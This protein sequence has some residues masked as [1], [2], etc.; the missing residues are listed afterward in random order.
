MRREAR[1][2]R[3]AVAILAC[4]FVSREAISPRDEELFA[5]G[6]ASSRLIIRLQQDFFLR[7]AQ[8]ADILILAGVALSCA[9]F[10]RAVA[11]PVDGPYRVADRKKCVYRALAKKKTMPLEEG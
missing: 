9:P 6:L 5:T 3:G 8:V 11:L 7:R 10:T 4:A 2:S 1:I